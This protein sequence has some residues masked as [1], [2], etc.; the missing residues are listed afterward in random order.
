MSSSI[1]S[2][3]NKVILSIA[4]YSVFVP[5]EEPL[6]IGSRSSSSR[7]TRFRVKLIA[8]SLAKSRSKVSLLLPLLS[9]QFQKRMSSHQTLTWLQTSLGKSLELI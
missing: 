7:L 4:A 9:K 2:T 8:A 1:F 5:A 3:V 6:T